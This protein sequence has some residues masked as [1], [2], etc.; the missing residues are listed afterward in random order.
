MRSRCGQSAL[1]WENRLSIQAWLV[2]VPGRPKCWAA[3]AHMAMNSRVEPD[4][5]C[6]PFIADGEQHWREN[7]NPGIDGERVERRLVLAGFDEFEQ[8]SV[9][10]RP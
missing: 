4:V 5:I 10:R 1:R 3:V 6:G 7:V 2:G 8:P 9:A